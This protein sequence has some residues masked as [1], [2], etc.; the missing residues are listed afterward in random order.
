VCVVCA[1]KNFSFSAVIRVSFSK[2]VAARPAISV[3]KLVLAM[4]SSGSDYYSS[5][6]YYHAV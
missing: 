1:C 2:Q 5:Q 4:C 6:D 3:Y